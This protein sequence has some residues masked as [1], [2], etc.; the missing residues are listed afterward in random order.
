MLFSA[1]MIPHYM[2]IRSLGLLDSRWALILP[3]LISA[4]NMI[5]VRN[6]FMNLPRDLMDS[7]RIDG[8]GEWRIFLK[9]GRASCRERG[10]A[11]GGDGVV[12]GSTDEWSGVDA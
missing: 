4:F 10:E 1:G 3:G 2:L 7:A 11:E 6:F 9:I 5:I 8:A 12:K